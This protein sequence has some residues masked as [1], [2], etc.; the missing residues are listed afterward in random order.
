MGLSA[1]AILGSGAAAVG[2]LHLRA[3]TDVPARA[4][5]PLA[6]DT[7]PVRLV[8]GYTVTDRFAGRLEPARQ[9]TL[10]FER[11][12]LVT[13]VLHDEGD[14][15][16]AGAI[17]AKLDTAKLEAERRRLT[18]QRHELEAKRDLAAFTLKRQDKLKAEGFRSAQAHDEAR[19]GLMEVEAAIERIDAAIAAIEIDIAKSALR[20]PFAGTLGARAI[21]EGAVVSAGTA[22]AD[23][24]ESGRAIVRVGVA[25]NAATRLDAGKRYPLRAGAD[26]VEGRLAALRP[27]LSTRTHTTI[28]L[29][30]IDENISLPFGEIV[31]LE[32]DRRIATPGIWVPVAALSEGRKGLWTVFSVDGGNADLAVS[33][34]TV[35]ILH[36]EAGRAFVRGTLADGAR[37]VTSGTNRITPGQTVVVA[38]AR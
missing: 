5:P 4:N 20:A 24:L 11:G 13:E 7:A 36:A 1:V 3:A 27:D 21:D 23:L 10:A 32:F 19:F 16:A 6:V 29:F 15:V 28:A 9:T 38:Q 8:D 26:T 35:E 30:E 12:G 14:R 22:V 2:V 25:V 18:A 33:R 37:V 34:E 17:V 31:E